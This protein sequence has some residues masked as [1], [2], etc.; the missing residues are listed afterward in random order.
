VQSKQFGD[1]KTQILPA[2]KS[3]LAFDLKPELVAIS[4]V[5]RCGNQSP[6][7]VMKLAK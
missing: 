1:W 5:D 3:S 7:A 4:A 2:S 6:P